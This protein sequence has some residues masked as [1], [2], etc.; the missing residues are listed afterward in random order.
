M[1][2]DGLRLLLHAQANAFTG[3]CTGAGDTLDLRHA[4]LRRDWHTH[5]G[6]GSC[7]SPLAHWATGAGVV[8]VGPAKTATAGACQL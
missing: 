1:R 4:A 2:D 6:G 7:T 8:V 3:V 5:P